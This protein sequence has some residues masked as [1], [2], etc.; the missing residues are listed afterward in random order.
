MSYRRLL[1]L[2]GLIFLLVVAQ[3]YSLG[4]ESHGSSTTQT[5]EGTA[6]PG[7]E[8]KLSDDIAKS[9]AKLF[10]VFTE[11]A[12]KERYGADLPK[13][14]EEIKKSNEEPIATVIAEIFG[15]LNDAQATKL[16]TDVEAEL[17]SEKDKEREKQDPNKINLLSRI[18]EAVLSIKKQDGDKDLAKFREAF[19]KKFKDVKEKNKEFYKLLDEALTNDAAKRKLLAGG[20]EPSLLL[21]FAKEQCASGNQSLC[22]KLAKGLTFEDAKGERFI[23]VVNGDQNQRLAIGKEAD[24]KD[25]IA[26][27]AEQTRGFS[28][29]KLASKPH[30]SVEEA[31]IVR[32]KKGATYPPPVKKDEPKKTPEV[33]TD[34][35]PIRKPGEGGRT[36]DTTTP[37]P[38]PP[39]QDTDA[40]RLAA[41]TTEV[42]AMAKTNC[43]GCH[44]KDSRFATKFDENGKLISGSVAAILDR[45]TKTTDPRKKMPKGG[46]L[47]ASE[48]DSIKEWARLQGHS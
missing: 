20:Y 47:S 17:K 25:S 43:A 29:L 6:R 13:A 5:S 21:R 26:D 18:K 4:E 30:E 3:S 7:A 39:R 32:P 23:D 1:V 12:V 8:T 37:P 31:N 9:L 19:E 16:L 35:A 46:S 27:I 11:E 34:P 22:D 40:V 10:P 42:E 41:K 24:F 28:G 15:T 33:T 14:F 48:I 36:S 2:Y 38:T 44:D 45:T